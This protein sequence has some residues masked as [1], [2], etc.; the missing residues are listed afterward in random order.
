M[1][2][3]WNFHEGDEIAPGLTAERLLGGGSSFE[4][5][6][7]FDARRYCPVVV[8]IVRPDRV[9]DESTLRGLERDVSLIGLVNHSV[10]VRFS[11][12]C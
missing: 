6:L 1:T 8:K 5:Y 10:I 11:R 7:A 3:S 9:E 2:S 4:A 12:P